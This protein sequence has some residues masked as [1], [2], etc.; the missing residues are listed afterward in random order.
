M[1]RLTAQEVAGYDLVPAEIARRARVQRVPVL[2]PGTSGMTLGRL[3]LLRCDDDRSG[4][5]TLVAHELV[6]AGQYAELGVLRF[7]GRYLGEYASNRMRLRNHKQ[8]YASISFEV[9]AR[10]A[11]ACWAARRGG[12]SL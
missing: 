6:H 12:E 5:C 4:Q 9:E 10:T 2:A 3:I 8:A 11:A 1:R 7:L